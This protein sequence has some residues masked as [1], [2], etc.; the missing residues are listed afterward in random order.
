MGRDD[1][2]QCNMN[3]RA[4]RIIYV[5]KDGRKEVIENE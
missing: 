4:K 5:S 3:E 1:K 2:Y